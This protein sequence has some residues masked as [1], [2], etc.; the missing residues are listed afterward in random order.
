[1][2]RSRTTR[3]LLGAAT[4]RGELADDGRSARWSASFV[5]RACTGDTVRQV[6]TP[7][8]ARPPTAPMTRN[9][10]TVRTSTGNQTSVAHVVRTRPDRRASGAA[11]VNTEVDAPEDAETD[12]EGAGATDAP[13][14][15]RDARCRDRTARRAARRSALRAAGARS[16]GAY[17]VVLM[18]KGSPPERLVMRRRALHLRRNDIMYII[19]AP[20]DEVYPYRSPRVDAIYI[21]ATQHTASRAPWGCRCQATL[22]SRRRNPWRSISSAIS[23]DRDLAQR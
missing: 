23:L 8:A 20:R 14:P 22:P 19:G 5:G 10:R 1:M 15:D 12:F 6:H 7:A 13:I 16:C 21:P 4:G 18:T 17:V 2:V 3:R 11:A 9:A